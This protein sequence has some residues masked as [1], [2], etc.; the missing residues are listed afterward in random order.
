M[1]ERESLLFY[2]S[3]DEAIELLSDEDQLKAYRAITKYGLYGIEP[4]LDGVSGAVF[5]LAKPQ[6]DANNRRYENGKRGGRPAAT[7]S[8]PNDTNKKPKQN[9]T[10]TKAKPK[11]N[12]TETKVKAK[13]KVKDKVKVKD[14]NINNIIVNPSR[15]LSDEFIEIWSLYPRKQGRANAMKYYFRARKSGTTFDEVKNG[16]AAYA[17]YI[18]RNK[19]E[20]EYIKQG[21]TFFN[22]SAWADD[23]SLTY[24]KRRPAAKFN[25]TTERETDMRELELKLLA[26]N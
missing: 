9:Q 26:T 5:L 20:Y 18:K 8:K 3:F 4:N 2:K 6:I 1:S 21:S 11:Q 12:Q 10:E 24:S 17:E 7:K 14:N 25:N 23:W 22:Q 16:V 19:I 13:D 15:T